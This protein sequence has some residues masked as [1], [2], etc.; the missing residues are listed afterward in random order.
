MKETDMT[1][2]IPTILVAGA[3]GMLG[4]QIAHAVLNRGAQV[5]L[6]V[7]AGADQDPAKAKLIDGLKA[8]GA[9][10]VAGD[11]TDVASVNAATKDIFTVVS[12]VQGGP[13]IIID[14]QVALAKA[15]A[16]NGVRRFIPSDFSVDFFKLP[17]NSHPNL[18]IRRTA[19]QQLA[20]VPIEVSHVLIGGFMEIVFGP[21]FQLVDR[22]KATVSYFG[23]ADTMFDV[24]TTADAAAIT[25]QA[26]LSDA[27][28]PGPYSFAGDVMTIADL[29]ETLSA[30]DGNEYAL[31][32]RGSVANLESYIAS[33]QAA[34]KAMAW[35]TLGAQYA[36]AMMSGRARLTDVVD[37]DF[38]P[39][40]VA[41]FLAK[42]AK[43]LR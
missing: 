30:V 1:S 40:T 2:P 27:A 41:Q 35:P 18:D 17:D 34:G 15:A 9:Q 33:E 25:A 42:P 8:R 12:A 28:I 21:M 14:G 32:H 37:A 31:V 11:L 4:A 24:T 29:A 20:A 19:A 6:L 16:A 13:D 22:E 23:D 38:T 10:T 39:A 43:Q 7:R 5:R 36:W 26:A 3:T